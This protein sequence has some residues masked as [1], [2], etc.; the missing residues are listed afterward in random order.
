M[1]GNSDDT[2]FFWQSKY[3]TETWMGTENLVDVTDS[4]ANNLKYRIGF[5]HVPSGK[6][7][8]FKAF[9]TNYK[10]D[11]ISD[12]KE[13]PIF[14]RTDGIYTYGSTKRKIS[15]SFDV[16]AASE[17]EAYEN[18]GRI[19]RLIQFQYPSYSDTNYSKDSDERVI[20][21]SPLVRISVM[22]LLQRTPVGKKMENGRDERT[23]KSRRDLLDGYIREDQSASAG[24][25]TAINS[26]SLDTDVGK[27]AIFEKAPGTVLPQFFSVSLDFFVI[28]EDTLGFDQQGNS[29]LPNYPWD[30]WLKEPSD[31]EVQATEQSTAARTNMLLNNQAAEDIAKARFSGLGGRGRAKRAMKKFARLKN[32]A[33]R[34][35]PNSRAAART[36]E[37]GFEYELAGEARDAFTDNDWEW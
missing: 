33:E 10:E 32:R 2:N 20:G 24:I 21:Q 3:G 25:L 36:Q 13:E 16:P 9:I 15:L 1:A 37:G 31:A 17:S 6:M 30:V 11:F 19:Q 34:W 23:K 26:L 14:G 5:Y 27:H 12:W 22:N 29:L 4:Y 18:M 7:V 8:Y 35:G 28:H